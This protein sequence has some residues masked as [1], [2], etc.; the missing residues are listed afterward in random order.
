MTGI[1]IAAALAAAVANAMAVV[2]QASEARRSPSREGMH[3][4][5][6]VRLAHRPRWLAGSGLIAVG[7]V[8]QILALA[9]APIAIVQPTLAT[10]MLWLLAVARLRLHQQV[11]LPEGLGALA[12]LA[13]LTAVIL[14]S[15]AH[16]LVHPGS[17]LVLPVVVVAGAGALASVLGRARPRAGL[18][19]VVGA[20]LAYSWSDFGSK[21][22]A[23]EISRSRWA[24]AAAWLAGVVVLGAVAFLEENTAL[25]RR[26][27]V[28]V[29]PVIDAIKVPLPVLMALWAGA[30]RWGAQAGQIAA[31]LGGLV[32]VA[33]GAASL[34]RSETVA[35]VSEAGRGRRPARAGG[36]TERGSAGAGG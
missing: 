33:A 18:L 26:P 15:P 17:G 35:K 10:D 12:I 14:A 34:G 32:V 7:G 27:A 1:G 2:L 25:Q 24:L 28:T 5:L 31:L 11:G 3:A 6:L 19:L 9:L 21:L 8:L 20:G 29:A 13:G 23:Q 16:A 4:S 30:E 36:R 22:L